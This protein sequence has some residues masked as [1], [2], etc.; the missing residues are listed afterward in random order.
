MQK[1]LKSNFKYVWDKLVYGAFFL[2]IDILV[3]MNVDYS[4]EDWWVWVFIFPWFVFFCITFFVDFML[5][6]Q[7]VV[8]TEDRISVRCL[9]YEIRSISVARIKR[10]WTCITEMMGQKGWVMRR[11]CIVIDTIRSR[12]AN[13][14][15]DG[16]CRKKQAYI[17]LPDAQP[18]RT[19][20]R[21]CGLVIEN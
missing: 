16:Y 18:N 8:I 10:C 21:E 4:P 15:I 11:D 14:I 3:L 9:L 6:W 17:I 20:L 12:R 1:R 13:T 2:A 5:K 19:A 7:W